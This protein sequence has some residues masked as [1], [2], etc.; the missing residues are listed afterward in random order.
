M[1]KPQGQEVLEQ[2][3]DFSFHIFPRKSSLEV[4]EGAHGLGDKEPAEY[5]GVYVTPGC[6]ENPEP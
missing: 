4:V 6:D 3:K 1:P 2:E 5:V